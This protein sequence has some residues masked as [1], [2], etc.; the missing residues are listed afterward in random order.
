MPCATGR[1]DYETC[2]NNA[3]ATGWPPVMNRG[4]R[5]LRVSEEHPR[6]STPTPEQLRCL[7]L[8]R[9]SEEEA[10]RLEEQLMQD[11]ET[12][13]LFRHEET[14]LVDDYAKGLLAAEDRRAFEQHLLA[15]PAIRQRVKVARA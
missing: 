6:M 14:D 4:D 5:T 15:D 10:Q 8:H 12:A 13:D 9:L 11:A 1:S 2:S 3:L 7:L